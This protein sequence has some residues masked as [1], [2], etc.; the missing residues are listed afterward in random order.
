MRVSE[1]SDKMVQSG[2]GSQFQFIPAGL[3]GLLFVVPMVTVAE[4]VQLLP[5]LAIT[6]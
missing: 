3:T 1:F 5:S 6:V 4:A 2:V